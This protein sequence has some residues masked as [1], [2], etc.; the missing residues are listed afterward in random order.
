MLTSRILPHVARSAYFAHQSLPQRWTSNTSFNS[1]PGVTKISKQFAATKKQVEDPTDHV[2]QEEKK[3]SRGQKRIEM[4]VDGLTFGGMLAGG[5]AI[6]RKI[7][8]NKRKE[9]EA[10]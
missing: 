8:T 9:A 2:S 3:N 6:G 10:N 1:R 4:L 5:V 7:L